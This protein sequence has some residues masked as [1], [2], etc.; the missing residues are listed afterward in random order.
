MT[1]ASAGNCH[2]IGTWDVKGIKLIEYLEKGPA[3]TEAFYIYLIRKLKA[4]DDENRHGIE[5]KRIIFDQYNAAVHK[6]VK[7]MG[8]LRELYCEVQ[9]HPFYSQ[10][11]VSSDFFV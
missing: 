3:I 11:L 2:A 8:K 6:N 4:K 7:T 10:D 5:E 9:E 1:K